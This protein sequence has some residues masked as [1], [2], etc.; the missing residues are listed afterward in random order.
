M[1][2]TANYQTGQEN[3]IH[4]PL[5][6]VVL[7][8]HQTIQVDA[9]NAQ[10]HVVVLSTIRQSR[11]TSLTPNPIYC[12]VSDRSGTHHSR[13]TPCSRTVNHQTGQEDVIFRAQ[14]SRQQEIK[15]RRMVW[16]LSFNAQICFN[17]HELVDQQSVRVQAP[18]SHIGTD[19]CI[20]HKDSI[21]KER[22]RKK[23]NYSPTELFWHRQTS[24]RS[25]KHDDN[26][27]DMNSSRL[28][29]TELFRHY[30][31]SLRSGKK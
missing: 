2:C 28:S 17:P 1:N 25:H 24:L 20:G 10:H 30:Q 3:I 9:I 14:T 22:T 4:A 19:H 5:H 21:L 11:K 6:L 29:F 15:L 23:P 27:V 13:L 12:Q 8:N 18:P 26:G 31:S 16:V 7:F